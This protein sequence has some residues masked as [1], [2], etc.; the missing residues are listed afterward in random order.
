MTSKS[1]DSAMM[2][3]VCGTIR[4][5]RIVT[6]LMDAIAIPSPTFGEAEVAA[7]FAEAMTAVGLDVHMMDV[8][9]PALPG[10]SSKQPIGRLKGSGEGP[11]LMFNGHMDTC[12]IMSGWSVDPFA[13]TFKDGWVWG[14]GAHDDKGGLVA[15][16]CGVEAI[17][18]SGTTLKGDVVVCPV[19]AHKAGGIGTRALLASGL[20]FDACVNIEHSTNTIA[21]SVVGIVQV[22]FTTRH[23]SLFFRYNEEAKSVYFNSIEQQA[24]VIHRL[25]P[26]ITPHGQDSWLTFTPHPDLLGFPM[27][28]FNAIHK[29]MGPRECDM[30]IEIRTVPGQ[31]DDRVRR[32]AQAVVDEMMRENPNLDIEI[33]VPGGG[34][35]DFYYMPAAEI[36]KSHPFV[37]A[38]ARGQAFASGKEPVIGGGLRIGNAGDGNLIA[39]AGIPCLQYGPGDIRNYAEWPG[40]D[41]RVEAT[42]LLEASKAM[43]YSAMSYCEALQR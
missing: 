39:D 34:E 43:A 22:K 29:T 32:D 21:T 23:K 31:S 10:K 16:I 12:E 8:S 24:D 28:R 42:Q 5:D 11:N 19:A 20:P 36:D 3:Q 37:T 4:Q 13:R 26:S 2:E 17:I 9:H 1:S 14:S 15:A 38:L 18:R 33:L 41:E 27:H 40:P 35:N 7:F 6:M 30:I 25:G